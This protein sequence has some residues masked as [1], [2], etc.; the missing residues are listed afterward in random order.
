MVAGST[1][2]P[3]R[4]GRPGMEVVPQLRLSG[5]SAQ[6]VK[7]VRVTATHTGDTPGYGAA[8]TLERKGGRC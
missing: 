2:T 5:V 7:E 6:W 1:D 3:C 8:N 4:R